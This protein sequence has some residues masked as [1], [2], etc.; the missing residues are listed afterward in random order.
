MNQARIWLVIKPSFGI[1]V[2][3]GTVVVTALIV[4]WAL[5]THTTWFP[6]YWQG[7]TKKA[8]MIEMAPSQVMLPATLTLT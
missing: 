5:L 8:A 2:M 3:L 6:A 7:G 4:H 1:P